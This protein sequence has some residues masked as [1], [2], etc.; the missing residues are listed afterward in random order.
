MTRRRADLC[1]DFSVSGETN[2]ARLLRSLR[3]AV[4]PGE[5]VFVSDAALPDSVRVYA[6]V[7]EDEGLSQVIARTDADELGIDYDFV[8]A[9]ITL[10][11]H[12]SLESIGLTAAVSSALSDQEISANV[13]AGRLH[14]HVLVPFD[15]VGEALSVLV[16]LASTD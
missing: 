2:L 16:G 11:V 13:I 10:H 5:F 8:G 12:S 9:W 6:S 4:L 15:R 3:P 1:E 14:D 7:V